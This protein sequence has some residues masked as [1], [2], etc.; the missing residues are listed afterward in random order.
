MSDINIFLN[1]DF[2][3]GG[4]HGNASLKRFIEDIDHM[5]RHDEASFSQYHENISAAF[6]WISLGPMMK[7]ILNLFNENEV[8]RVKGYT[9]IKDE[10]CRIESEWNK[11]TLSLIKLGYSSRKDKI[12]IIIEN[13]RNLICGQEKALAALYSHIKEIGLEDDAIETSLYGH[14]RET[15]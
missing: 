7:Y 13:C 11:F 8:L 6:K 10:F 5:V 4:L 9:A 12:G 3:N 15:A 1:C 14:S 2:I